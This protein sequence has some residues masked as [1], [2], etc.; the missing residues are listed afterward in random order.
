MP[1]EVEI[2]NLAL[3]YLGEPAILSLTDTGDNAAR[4]CAVN[5]SQARDEALSAAQWSCAKRQ[6]ALPRLGAAPLYK[7]A[8]AYQLPTDFLRLCEI[9]G[10]N[11]WT[12]AEYFDRQ[13]S[14]LLMGRGVDAET[15]AVVCI[16]YIA[17]IEDTTQFDPLLVECLALILGAKMAR[18]LTG[19]DAKGPQLREEYER[20]ALPKARTLNAQQIYSGKNHP[21]RQMLGGSFLQKARRSG[22]ASHVGLE[23]W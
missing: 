1:S 23:T 12:P 7:W 20:V 13:G 3:Q 19:S 10:S 18:T 15:Y 9:D 8:A 6:A 2:C 22:D 14:T 21:I 16:E 11:A 4:T 17:R 5:F